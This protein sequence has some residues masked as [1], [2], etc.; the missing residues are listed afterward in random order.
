[1]EINDRVKE[2][3]TSLGLS[4]TKFGE[5]IGISKDMVAN[6]EYSRVDVKPAVIKLICS[7]H[8]IKEE[9]LLTGSGDMYDIPMDED[10]TLIA[11][12]LKDEKSEIAALC[13][14]I[15]RA[16]KKMDAAGKA[17]LDHYIQMLKEDMN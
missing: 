6:I 11:E 10:A 12:L 5:S 1:M 15:L 3:R 2:V 13:I 17:T 9:W 8:N 14:S 16:Y 7:T 4:M